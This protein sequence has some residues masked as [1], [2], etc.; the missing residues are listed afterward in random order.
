M[1]G[2]VSP[3]LLAVMLIVGCGFHLR[4]QADLSP[5]LAKTHIVGVSP[6]SEFAANLRQQLRANG[7][8]I[9][10]AEQSTSTLRITRNVGGKR[11][12]SVDQNGKVLEF[13]LYSVIS[14]E[15]RGQNK[16]ILLKN[17][18]ISLSRSFLFDVNDVLGK[19]EEEAL[20]R[21]DL[22]EDV[23]RLIIYRLQAIGQS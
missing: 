10:D 6:Y 5:E 18:T 4:G 22:Q 16:T 1:L 20:L 21:E 8:Q 12:L 14:F 17:Q 23:V 13:E 19:A 7:V 15:V 11:V 9:V 2:W 3:I